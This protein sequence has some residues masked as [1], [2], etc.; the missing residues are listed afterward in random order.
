MWSHNNSGNKQM[1]QIT[2]LLKLQYSGSNAKILKAIE[3]A[4]ALLA[5]AR[6]IEDKLQSAGY[7][8]NCVAAQELKGELMEARW[9]A[10]GAVA[11]ARKMVEKE[12]V[13]TVD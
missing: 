3:Q 8:R 4:N 12:A 2:D 13:S 10:L 1:E 5:H 9:K 11:A 7:T 6:T